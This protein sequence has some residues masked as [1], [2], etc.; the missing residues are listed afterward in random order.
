MDWAEKNRRHENFLIPISYC[1]RIDGY[2]VVRA[3]S[4]RFTCGPGQ[5]PLPPR[6]VR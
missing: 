5:R 4:G 2:S 3:K 6:P 1:G